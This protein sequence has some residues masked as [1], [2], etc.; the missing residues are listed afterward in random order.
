MI[1]VSVL[2]G[3][4]QLLSELDAVEGSP[5][6]ASTEFSRGVLESEA[7]GALGLGRLVDRHRVVDELRDA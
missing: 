4:C 1:E 2:L 7:A 3:D 6:P 5:V